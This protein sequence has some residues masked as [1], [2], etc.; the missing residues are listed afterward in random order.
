M[1]GWRPTVPGHTPVQLLGSILSASSA[2]IDPPSAAKRAVTPAIR[3]G[4][5]ARVKIGPCFPVTVHGSKLMS[6][7]K[8]A[9][10]VRFS[11]TFR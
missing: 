5:F 10:Y 11:I 3:V 4:A 2:A 1:P 6:V 8:E 7:Q 9:E